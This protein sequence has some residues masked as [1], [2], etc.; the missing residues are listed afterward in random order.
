MIF[1]EL[2]ECFPLMV[3]ENPVKLYSV[4]LLFHT[5]FKANYTCLHAIANKIL[6]IHAVTLQKNIYTCVV[7]QS[8]AQLV[9]VYYTMSFP[10]LRSRVILRI[11]TKGLSRVA[12]SKRF[13][14]TIKVDALFFLC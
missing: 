5:C 2:F 12:L 3:T 14:E 13:H 11:S 4:L 6:L 8:S 1:F 7:S 9:H 10:L